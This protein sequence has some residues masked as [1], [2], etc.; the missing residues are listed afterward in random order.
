M[1]HR[2]IQQWYIPL[3]NSPALWLVHIHRGRCFIGY[4]Q[5]HT[6]SSRR[7]LG[8]SSY[9]DA[10]GAPRTAY[11]IN[12]RGLHTSQCES[13]SD[14]S[15]SSPGVDSTLP[16]AGDRQ[17]AKAEKQ[18]RRR[19]KIDEI[20]RDGEGAPRSRRQGAGQ[21][22]WSKKEIVTYDIPTPAGEKKGIAQELWIKGNGS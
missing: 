7:F 6:T 20:Q 14:G 2:G 8:H 3:K 17:R 10:Q 16:G 22:S 18:R 15:S 4:K 21:K 9:S 11:L 1:L 12:R 5:V 19:E 13:T